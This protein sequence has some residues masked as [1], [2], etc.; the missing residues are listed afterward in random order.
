M[1]QTWL[2]LKNTRESRQ[3][4]LFYCSRYEIGF[5]P[6]MHMTH[7]M[8][9]NCY[10]EPYYKKKILLTK[11]WRVMTNILLSFMETYVLEEEQHIE[12]VVEHKIEEQEVEQY[13][14]GFFSSL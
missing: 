11:G 9:E 3:A 12:Q 2:L 4:V 10:K 7:I 1:V 13:P 8:I 5:I 14:P 6:F